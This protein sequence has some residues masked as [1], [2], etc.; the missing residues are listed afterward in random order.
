L[1]NDQQQAFL[2]AELHSGYRFA[3]VG[4]SVQDSSGASSSDKVI[5]SVDTHWANTGVTPAYNAWN[6]EFSLW[7]PQ[8]QQEVSQW[9]SKV[10]LRKILPTGN[11]PVAFFDTLGI[12]DNVAPGTYEL[13]MRVT[14]PQGYM[15][16]M[17]LALQGEMRDGYYPLG[18]VA[19]SK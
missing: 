1:S 11:T 13:R 16:P 4:I 19:I 9:T 7:N 15:N 3:P 10:D 5:L 14:D 6:V 2:W 8:G 17:K 12:G 18:L